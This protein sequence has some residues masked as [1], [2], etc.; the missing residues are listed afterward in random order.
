MTSV[1]AFTPLRSETLYTKDIS[2]DEKA[3]ISWKYFTRDMID[4]EEET[5]MLLIDVFREI[6]KRDE[7]MN[8]S[9]FA[10][11]WNENKDSLND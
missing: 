11:W 4:V 9:E 3:L 1:Q 7:G 6:D 2:V 8:E 10:I 5:N